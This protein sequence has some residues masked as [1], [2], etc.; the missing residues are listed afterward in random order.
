[1]LN[2]FK[3]KKKIF[4]FKNYNKAEKKILILLKK[5]KIKFICLSWLYENFI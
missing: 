1:M 3:I 2:Q 4:N 5:E